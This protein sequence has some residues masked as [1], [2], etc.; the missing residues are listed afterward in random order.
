MSFS[1]MEKGLGSTADVLHSGGIY[2]VAG[3]EDSPT[4][5][6]TVVVLRGHLTMPSKAL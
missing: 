6:V 1:L 3:D 5:R 2:I 4:C